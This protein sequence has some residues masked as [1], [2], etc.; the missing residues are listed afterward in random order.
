MAENLTLTIFRGFGFITFVNLE[1]SDSA[2]N[3]EPHI[4]DGK[5][6]SYIVVFCRLT[7]I[8]GIEL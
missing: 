5:K 2:V 3:H 1:D 7:N 6:V 8:G 4:L